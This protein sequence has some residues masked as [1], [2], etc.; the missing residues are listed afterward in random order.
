MAEGKVVVEMDYG[1]HGEL[2]MM[3]L[4]ENQIALLKTKVSLEGIGISFEI[5][6]QEKKDSTD[7]CQF[8]LFRSLVIECE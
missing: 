2:V 8:S 7:I 1:D 5:K 6:S 4:P 3:V